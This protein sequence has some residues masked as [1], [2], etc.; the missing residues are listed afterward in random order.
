M[1]TGIIQ[2]AHL[3]INSGKNQLSKT[4]PLLSNTSRNK[5]KISV[6]LVQ[7]PARNC[8]FARKNFTHININEVMRSIAEKSPSHQVNQTTGY[9]FEVIM[10]ATKFVVAPIVQLTKHI[11][12]AAN[13]NLNI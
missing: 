3:K 9:C 1:S 6:F 7:F 4:I 8:F 11:S 13:E 5:T 12:S 10:P 2:N